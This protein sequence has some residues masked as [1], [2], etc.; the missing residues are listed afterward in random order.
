VPALSE[1]AHS[2][3]ALLVVAITEG[4][5]LVRCVLLRMPTLS[6][7]KGKVSDYRPSYG[8]PFVWRDRFRAR[9]LYANAGAVGR[10]DYGLGRAARFVLTLRTREQ[11]IRRE[12]QPRIF[13]QSRRFAR[14]GT[15]HLTL[16]AKKPARDGPANLSKA[17]FALGDSRKPGVR[18]RSRLRSSTNLRWSCALVKIVNGELLRD[19]IVCPVVL[20]HRTRN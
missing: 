15:V 13:H 7:W 14:C 5:S 16:L 10:S 9:N 8:G 2:A 17:R 18:R 3:G 12:G 11:H 20:A 1:I 6:L 19:K 4:V